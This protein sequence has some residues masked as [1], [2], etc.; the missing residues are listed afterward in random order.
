MGANLSI[1]SIFFLLFLHRLHH[2]TLKDQQPGTFDHKEKEQKV[3]T[4]VD[5][6]AK[7]IRLLLGAAVVGWERGEAGCDGECVLEEKYC[8]HIL[9]SSLPLI[10]LLAQFK[11]ARHMVLSLDLKV[12]LKT[13]F[14]F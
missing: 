4:W 9:L 3:G 12:M 8:V 11:G 10:S 6:G 2:Q 14:N 7:A 1:A 5:G 13:V